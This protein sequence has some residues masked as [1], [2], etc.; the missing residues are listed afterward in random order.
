MI[1][2]GRLVHEVVA[3]C[4][5][6]MLTYLRHHPVMIASRSGGQ[7]RHIAFII[8]HRASTRLSVSSHHRMISHII[9]LIPL[10]SL[11]FSV[12][13]SPSI[14]PPPPPLF[15]AVPFCYPVLIR[16][17]DPSP[18]LPLFSLFPPVRAVSSP[19]SSTPPLSLCVVLSSCLSPPPFFSCSYLSRFSSLLCVI[20]SLFL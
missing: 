20:S 7:Q 12:F 9:V 16:R 1:D 8:R 10:L 6:I 4:V 2:R 15:L 13:G 19:P 17:M 5:R 14:P 11:P 3:G 18:F